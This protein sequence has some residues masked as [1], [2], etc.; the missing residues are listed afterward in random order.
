MEQQP[1]SFY[2]DMVAN[3]LNSYFSVA[4][5]N[6]I[7][8]NGSASTS[9]RVLPKNK[10][11]YRNA[12]GTPNLGLLAK[13]CAATVDSIGSLSIDFNDYWGINFVFNASINGSSY[14]HGS[15]PYSP[16]LDGRTI[17]PTT[18]LFGGGGVHMSV[19][20]HEMGHAF[21]MDHSHNAAGGEYGNAWDVMSDSDYNCNNGYRDPVFGC[22][23]QHPNIHNKQKA[24]WVPTN[25]LE[26]FYLHEDGTYTI[27]LQ[28]HSLTSTNTNKLMIKIFSS[29]TEYYVIEARKAIGFD[30]K[31]QRTGV[32]IHKKLNTQNP[33]KLIDQD[34]DSDS[35]DNEAY[36]VAGESI[37]LPGVNGNIRITVESYHTSYFK[38]RVALPVQIGDP[39]K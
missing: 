27:D 5:N 2:G 6:L 12:S 8:L 17:I 26:T 38:V 11:E 7:N 3:E 37:N 16:A 22:I 24:G 35:L 31:L 20:A 32:V 10:D 13:D 33:L 14:G 23:P 1:Q 39:N 36:L 9:W 30:S 28:I 25:R 29:S 21:G 34:N 4:S 18:W 15:W 19:Y